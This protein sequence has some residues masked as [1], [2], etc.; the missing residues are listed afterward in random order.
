MADERVVATQ[1]ERI[2]QYHGELK[3][4]Q[5]S[6]SREVF[7]TDTTQQRAVERMFENAIQAC[8]DLAKHVAST[9]F[10]FEGD[11][12]KGAIR[13]LGRAE[14]I[15]QETTETLVAAFGF[16]NVLA[17]QYGDVDYDEVYENLQTGLDI[18][19]AFSRQVAQWAREQG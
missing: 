2:E 7:L 6:L 4:K 9:D 19:D 16:R 15:D 3:A 8:A 14:V 1:L 17:H 10:D 5:R 12:S 11:T 18:Y 13:A